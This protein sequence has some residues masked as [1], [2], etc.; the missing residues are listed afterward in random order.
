MNGDG[1]SM[2]MCGEKQPFYALKA[3]ILLIDFIPRG[4]MV[5]KNRQNNQNQALLKSN[6]TSKN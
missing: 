4:G 2:D 1:E 5:Q 6:P 3:M